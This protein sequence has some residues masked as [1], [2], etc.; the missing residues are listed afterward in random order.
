MYPETFLTLSK[1]KN[2]SYRK[3]RYPRSW[4]EGKSLGMDYPH[5]TLITI[6]CFFFL[7]F[8]VMCGALTISFS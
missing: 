1:T 7:V 4:K 5:T 6:L 2:I 8:P 3:F